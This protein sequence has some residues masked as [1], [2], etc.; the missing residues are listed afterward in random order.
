MSDR[1][2]EPKGKTT[3]QDRDEARR[4]ME[5]ATA[6]EA[7]SFAL[8][9]VN[10]LFLV[11]TGEDTS[12]YKWENGDEDEEEEEEE[13]EEDGGDDENHGGAAEGR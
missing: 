12:L 8:F 11:R 3:K 9:T 4:N 7:V 13:E 10:G 2:A 5:A 6:N 1:E